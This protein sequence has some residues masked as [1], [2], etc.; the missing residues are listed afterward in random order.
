MTY[1][2][3]L[4]HLVLFI[5]VLISTAFTVIILLIITRYRRKFPVFGNSFFRLMA[6]HCVAELLM[7]LQFSILMRGRKFMWLP[8]EAIEAT[9]LWNILP[10]ISVGIHYYM[11][12]VLYISHL[13]FAL[14][15]LSSCV[16]PTKYESF[17]SNKVIWTAR[18]I[19]FGLPL[20]IVGYIPFNLHHDI[21]FHKDL[22]NNRIR[23]HLGE[24]STLLTSY[25]DGIGCIFCGIACAAIYTVVSVLVHRQAKNNSLHRDGSEKK[26]R[27]HSLRT[28]TAETR[29]LI[30]AIALCLPLLMNAVI[31]V[32]LMYGASSRVM[33]NEY[34]LYDFG[35]PGFD[36]K[37]GHFT[38]LVW[39]ASRKLGTGISCDKNYCF[40]VF[41]Y[42]VNSHVNGTEN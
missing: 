41:H 5:F 25:I 34:K 39:K 36:E 30:T 20:L 29:I 42:Q 24:K 6:S 11:K 3:P 17:W 7:F 26:R 4:H 10:R 31:Q 15:R 40:V 22:E 2:L 28:L 18:V 23:L 16:F 14:N 13:N 1:I 38:Q 21:R 9:F 32:L 27:S 35:N 8:M 12:S 33:F 19:Q 37:A